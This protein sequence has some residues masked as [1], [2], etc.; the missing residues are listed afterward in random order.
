MLLQPR[1][2]KY[3]KDQKGRRTSSHT[4]TYHGNRGHNQKALAGNLQAKSHTLAFGCY[5]LKSLEQSALKASQIEAVR[6]VLVRKAR[7]I[8]KI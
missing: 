7:R 5:G 8:G 1:N 2:R 6:R 3:R 4:C